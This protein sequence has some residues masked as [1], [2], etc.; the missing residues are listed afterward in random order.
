MLAHIAALIAL[1]PGGRWLVAFVRTRRQ[2]ARTLREI[3]LTPWTRSVLFDVGANDGSN[4]AVVAASFP[5]IHVYAFEPTPILID[6][7]K[8]RFSKHKNFHV[9]PT[10]VGQEEGR[11]SFNV[12]GQGDWGCSS[13]LEFSDDVEKTWEGRN[14]LKFTDRIQVDMVRLDTY[15][16]NN[17]IVRI[18]FLHIDTQGTDVGVLKSLGEELRCVRAGVIEVP[19]NDAVMLYKNQHTRQEAVDFLEKSGFRIWKVASQQNEDNLF[20]KRD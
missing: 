8:R 12:A 13:V 15:I 18:D 9:V 11:T 20:F 6:A 16:R 4:F 2:A 5:W 19:Q 1:V 14:D 17:G 10:A 3:G 7:M